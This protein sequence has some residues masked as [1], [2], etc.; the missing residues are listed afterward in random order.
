MRKQQKNGF[1]QKALFKQK[2]TF[3]AEIRKAFRKKN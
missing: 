3:L 1:T 2:F